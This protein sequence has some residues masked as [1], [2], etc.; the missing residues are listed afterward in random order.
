MALRAHAGGSIVVSTAPEA[1]PCL[2]LSWRESMAL[3]LVGGSWE[4]RRQVMLQHGSKDSDAKQMQKGTSL[5]KCRG[6]ALG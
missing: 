2:P 5:R 1:S 6:N 3:N 4:V